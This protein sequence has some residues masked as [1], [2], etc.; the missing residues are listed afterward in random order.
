MSTILIVLI[1]LVNLWC[2]ASNWNQVN[3]THSV[4]KQHLDFRDLE[5]LP[6]PNTDSWLGEY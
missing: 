3:E 1:V 2:N 4:L 5:D 6:Q